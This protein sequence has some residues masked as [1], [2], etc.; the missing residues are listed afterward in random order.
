MYVK[1]NPND[2]LF[3]LFGGVNLKSINPEQAKAFAIRE[4]ENAKKAVEKAKKD[5]QKIIH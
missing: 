3:S 1:E 2:I 4:K 5:K